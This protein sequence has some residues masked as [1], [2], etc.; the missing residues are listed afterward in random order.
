MLLLRFGGKGV[1]L[2]AGVGERVNLMLCGVICRTL[3]GQRKMKAM[4]V[5]QNN[6]NM[7]KNPKTKPRYLMKKEVTPILNLIYWKWIFLQWNVHEP[8]LSRTPRRNIVTTLPG[9]NAV[10]RNAKTAYE[11]WKLFFPDNLVDDIVRCTNEQLTLMSEKYAN[12]AKV[13]PQTDFC[14]MEAFLGVLYL[15]GVKKGSQPVLGCIL[16]SKKGGKCLGWLN[17]AQKSVIDEE[18]GDQLKPELIT[19]Y[20]LTK[21]GVGVV[22]RMKTEYCVTRVSNRRPLTVLCSW[23][24]WSHKRRNNFEGQYRYSF[25]STKIF[26]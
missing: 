9:V 13:F 12:G 8:T 23:L 17:N 14:E 7:K 11:S 1:R 20:N 16:H 15:A 19:F 10:A 21:G 25:T 26:V 24:H 3:M 2:G 5:T 22:D 6:Q 18:S 4:T